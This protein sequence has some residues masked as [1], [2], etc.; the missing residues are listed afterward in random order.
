M[1]LGRYWEI[2]PSVR[3]ALFENGDRAGYSKLKLA[4]AEVKA[5]IFGHAEF[6]RFNNSATKLFEKRV[7]RSS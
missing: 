7:S 2:L 1:R 3:S 6:T 4:T 5:A